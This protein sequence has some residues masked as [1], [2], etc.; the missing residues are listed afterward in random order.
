MAAETRLLAIPPPAES[1]MTISSGSISQVPAAP[2]GAEASGLAFSVKR[3]LAD[4][5]MKPPSPEI[6]PPLAVMTPFIFA[7]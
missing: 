5:S 3:C 4:V 6:L 7:D 1:V 2:F